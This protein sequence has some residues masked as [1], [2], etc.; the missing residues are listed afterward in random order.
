MYR[1]KQHSTKSIKYFFS[2]IGEKTFWLAERKYLLPPTFHLQIYNHSNQILKKI[3]F[4]FLSNHPVLILQHKLLKVN[5]FI[6]ITALMKEVLHVKHLKSS[7]FYQI[8]ILMSK[9]YVYNI[10][11]NKLIVVNSYYY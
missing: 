5:I 9:C 4:L 11:Y 8:I 7:Y 3:H 10:F 1:L 2:Q 6:T